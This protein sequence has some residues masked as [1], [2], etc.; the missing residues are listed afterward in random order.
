MTKEVYSGRTSG[1][2]DLSPQQ[3]VKNRG[4]QQELL[5]AQGFDLPVLDQYA[6]GGEGYRAIRGREQQLIDYNGGA[7]SVGGT[8][9]NAIQGVG[10]WNPRRTDYMDMS[11]K[12]FGGP[13]PDKSP[14]RFRFGSP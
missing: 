7:Q 12:L 6:R 13:L 2:G 1:S 9:R 3:I 11:N 5:N 8:A 14:P 10:D 4:L